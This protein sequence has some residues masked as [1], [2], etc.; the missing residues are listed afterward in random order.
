MNSSILL[1]LAL[2]FLLIQT[3]TYVEMR[4]FD[5]ET[6]LRKMEKGII[7]SLTETISEIL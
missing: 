3:V 6:V 1:T 7:E 2:L 4:S 5:L